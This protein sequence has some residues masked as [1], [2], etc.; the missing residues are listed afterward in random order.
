MTKYEKDP[1]LV[2]NFPARILTIYHFPQLYV[3]T[4]LLL[5]VY[6]GKTSHFLCMTFQVNIEILGYQQL[7]G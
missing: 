2:V 6:Q 3:P 4:Q 1:K 5:T 7:S